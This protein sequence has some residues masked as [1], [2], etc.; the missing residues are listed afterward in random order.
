MRTAYGETAALLQGS[1]GY[2]ANV[3]ADASISPS[4]ISA[5]TNGQHTQNLDTLGFSNLELAYLATKAVNVTFRGATTLCRIEGVSVT[6]DLNQARFT[7]YISPA[8]QTG[9]F[10]LDDSTFGVLDQNRLGLY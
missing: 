4:S 2:W 1:A 3:A 8:E 9:W 5:T 6:A 7:Y 10:I